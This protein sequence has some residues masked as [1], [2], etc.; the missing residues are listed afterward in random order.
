MGTLTDYL[1]DKGTALRA[2]K[3]AIDAGELAPKKLT[4]KVSAEGRSGL[5]R[6]RIRDFQ[7][8]TDAPPDLA[9][10]SMLCNR[11]TRSLES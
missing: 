2:R 10:C 8:V 5:R 9:R 7:F 1:Q 6:V 4:A 3:R 11:P